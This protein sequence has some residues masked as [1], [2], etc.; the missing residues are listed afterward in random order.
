L[1]IT[2]EKRF[3]D[4]PGYGYIPEGKEL[5]SGWDQDH[6]IIDPITN[7][8]YDEGIFVGYRWYENKGIDPL[9]AFGH[10]LSYTSFA[11]NNLKLENE[12]IKAGDKLNLK[13]DIA[14]TGI[15]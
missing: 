2:I 11:Y 6:R 13:I 1:P 3:E 15:N 8:T 12:S 4:S 7:V 14:N 9:Y 10:G 5:Y